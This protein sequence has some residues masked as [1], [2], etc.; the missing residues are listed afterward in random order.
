MP[1]ARNGISDRGDNMIAASGV[2]VNG[3]RTP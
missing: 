1:A 3:I 2:Y